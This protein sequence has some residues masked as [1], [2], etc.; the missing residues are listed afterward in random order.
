MRSLVS[1]TSPTVD[2]FQRP[3]VVRPHP[4]KRFTPRLDSAHEHDKRPADAI[5]TRGPEAPSPVAEAGSAV[6]PVAEVPGQIGRP[7]PAAVAEAA[8]AAAAGPA[9]SRVPV[10]TVQH[11]MLVG[12]AQA[13][14]SPN[15]GRLKR[16]LQL[17]NR[18]ILDLDHLRKVSW[19]GIPAEVRP[20]V[21]KLLSGYLPANSDRRSAILERRRA[22]YRLSVDQ[23]YP[24][25]NDKAHAT[26]LHQIQVDVLRS[27]P[28]SLF[29]Q[30]IAK[31][32]FERLLFVFYVR[33]PGSGYVQGMNDL[34]VPF[35]TVFLSPYCGDDPTKIDLSTVPADVLAQVE[36]DTYWCTAILIGKIQDYFT[37]DRTGLQRQLKALE[38]LIT[39]I[40]KPLEEHLTAN[41]VSYVQFAFRWMNCLLMREMPLAPIVRLWDAYLAE[42]DGFG[43]LHLYTCAALMAT[44][45][46][47]IREASDLSEIMIFILNLPTQSWTSRDVSML[48]AEAYRRQVF[49]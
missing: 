37:S 39:R 18:P 3:S 9:F 46:A 7:G 24:Q 25:R 38:E 33:H 28:S 34:A 35:F 49:I 6:A 10:A 11:G 29:A 26:M 15:D 30:E 8:T 13:P 1:A 27:T 22:E 31:Q 42:A 16:F 44:F 14:A 17:L 2:G 36:A 4:F 40:D 20:T 43:T 45:S 47:R 23:H 12:G 19:S 5:P 48:L 32:C 21:W 41:H